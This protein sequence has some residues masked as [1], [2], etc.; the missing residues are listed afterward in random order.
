[1][2]N[3]GDGV[4]GF[5]LRFAVLEAGLGSEAVHGGDAL[6][7]HSAVFFAHPAEDRGY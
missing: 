6:G 5:V 3:G 4:S 7:D 2:A 1:V